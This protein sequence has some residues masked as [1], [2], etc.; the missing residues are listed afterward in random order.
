MKLLFIADS[1]SIHTVRWVNFLQGNGHYVYYLVKSHTILKED[2][3]NLYDC[4][5]ANI[6][7]KIRAL[8]CALDSAHLIPDVLIYTYTILNG[9]HRIRQVTKNMKPDVIHVHFISLFGISASIFSYH[10]IILSAWGSD[11]LRAPRNH[12]YQSLLKRALNKADCITTTS[13][14]MRNLIIN[15]YNVKPSSVIQ[16]P[17]GIDLNTFK[18]ADND[19]ISFFKEKLH[20]NQAANV[21]IS[22]RSMVP[23]NYILNIVEALPIV[24]SKHPNTIFIFIVGLNNVN[25]EYVTNIKARLSQMH[26]DSNIRF[27]SR[28]LDPKEMNDFLNISDI[29]VSLAHSHD[30]FAATILEGMRCGVAPIVSHGEVYK[31]YL[32]D[33]ENALFVVFD[34]PDDIAEKINYCIEN[35]AL[36]KSFAEING[37]IVKEHEDWAKNAPNMENLYNSVLTQAKNKEI[38]I[39]IK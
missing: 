38:H 3:K 4:F 20:I 16:L 12:L 35:P 10:P 37:S 33:G 22:P 29:L 14:H 13:V 23:Q 9:L 25:T 27:I 8:Y 7:A 21:I 2:G 36:R 1:D 19:S 39:N 32:C 5:L 26:L 31:Q 34:N 6:L 11:I 28:M 18:R 30:Q 17:W 24:V 15:K